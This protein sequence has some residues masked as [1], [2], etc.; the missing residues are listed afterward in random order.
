MSTRGR[1][2]SFD[3]DA[4]LLAA[5][6]LFWAR[7]YDGT[8]LSDLTKAMGISPSSFYAAFGDKRSLFAE[9]VQGYM[10]RYT[11]IY[12]EAAQSPTAREAAER[13]LRDSVDEFTDPDRPMTCLVVSA[14]IHG[15]SDTIDVRQTLEQHQQGL[16]AILQERIEADRSTGALPDAS[17]PALLT[18]W[19]RTLWEGLSNQSNAGVPRARL[20]EIITVALRAWPS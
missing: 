9:A 2:R 17:D 8:S 6:R 11:A 5:T 18:D 12:V 14:A 20:H 13:I 15:G 4:A 1:P 3:R 10:Q 16:A 7:G 19:V